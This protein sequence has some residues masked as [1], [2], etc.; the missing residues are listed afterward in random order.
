MALGGGTVHGGEDV[1]STATL[2]EGMEE[3]GG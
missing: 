3:A 2:I 1:A